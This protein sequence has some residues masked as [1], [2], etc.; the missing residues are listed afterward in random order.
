MALSGPL[1]TNPGTSRD[2]LPCQR[3]AGLPCGRTVDLP[4]GGHV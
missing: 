1:A 3:T 4:A 2:R